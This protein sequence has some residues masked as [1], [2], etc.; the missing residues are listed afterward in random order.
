[1][2]VNNPILITPQSLPNLGRRE[3]GRREFFFTEFEVFG[4]FHWS[5]MCHAAPTNYDWPMPITETASL[6]STCDLGDSL[7]VCGVDVL[8]D[9][10]Y[11]VVREL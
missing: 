11:G 2:L 4:I 3:F 1:M 6:Q 7:S 9:S 10:Q 5:V 8:V